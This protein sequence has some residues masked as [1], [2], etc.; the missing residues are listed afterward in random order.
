MP[1]RVGGNGTCSIQCM[2]NGY[3]RTTKARVE[4][5]RK[6]GISEKKES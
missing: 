4:I 2:N 1:Q 3:V 6:F 5:V